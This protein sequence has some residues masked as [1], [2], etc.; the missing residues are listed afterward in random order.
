[1][2]NYAEYWDDYY[3]FCVIRNPYDR[4]VSA[5]H[6]FKRLDRVKL[7]LR[8]KLMQDLLKQY[9]CFGDFVL[10]YLKDANLFLSRK[11]NED[12]NHVVRTSAGRPHN[13]TVHFYPQINWLLNPNGHYGNGEINDDIDIFK[14]EKLDEVVQK[15]TT[16]YDMPNELGHLNGSGEMRGHGSKRNHYSEYYTDELYEVIYKKYQKDFELLGYDKNDRPQT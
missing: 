9:S 4:V 5:Y 12:V 1:M 6:H 15:L 3:K 16:K 10:D 13:P 2:T 8:P 14:F 11:E 7:S